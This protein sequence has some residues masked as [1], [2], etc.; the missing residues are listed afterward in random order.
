MSF[1][2]D[3]KLLHPDAFYHACTYYERFL[4]VLHCL[5]IFTISWYCSLLPKGVIVFRNMLY[6][7]AR[8]MI[9]LAIYWCMMTVFNGSF[10]L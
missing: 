5:T 3:Y 6:Y 2:I 7:G 10:S 1:V 9:L 4:A 8:S